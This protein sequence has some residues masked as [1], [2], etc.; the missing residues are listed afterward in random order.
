MGLIGVLTDSEKRASIFLLLLVFGSC[1]LGIEC[2]DMGHM[3][4]LTELTSHS[5][6]AAIDCKEVISCLM[7]ET[8]LSL[9][10]ERPEGLIFELL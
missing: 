3:E 7:R 4:R 9:F 10:R 1:L 6:V 2:L 5:T 8:P